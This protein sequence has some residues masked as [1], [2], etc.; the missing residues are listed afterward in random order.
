MEAAV[1]GARWRCR[2]WGG[3]GSELLRGML[4]VTA[5]QQE[6]MAVTRWGSWVSA[7]R[8]PFECEA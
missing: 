7:A 3:V 8:Y 2:T 5:S 1:Q 6:F 4:L